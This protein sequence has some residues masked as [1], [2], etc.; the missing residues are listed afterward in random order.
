[1]RC[2]TAS[3]RLEI[4]FID[5]DQREIALAILGRA[6]FA[7]HRIARAQRKAPD[8]GGGDVDIFRAGQVIGFRVA[9]KAE[10][11]GQNFQ[12]AV[13]MD[14]LVV[15]R[16]RLEDREHHVLLAQLGRVLDLQLLSEVEKIRGDLP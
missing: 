14:R 16:E 5:L 2:L 6:D 15:L 1:M 8:L 13:A 4:D 11:V 7:V 10:T 12:R 9:Q 3:G